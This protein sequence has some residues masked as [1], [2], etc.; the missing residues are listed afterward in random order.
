[1]TCVETATLEDAFTYFE[2]VSLDSVRPDRV[3]TRGGAEV[4]L[5]GAGLIDGSR[6]R[7]GGAEAIEVTP[8]E[9]SGD[10]IVIVPPGPPGPADVEVTNFNGRDRLPGGIFYY[11]DLDVQQINPPVGP[12]GGGNQVELLGNGLLAARG[13]H[14]VTMRQRCLGQMMNARS[15]RS[16]HHVVPPQGQR[17]SSSKTTTVSVNSTT[18]TSILMILPTTFRLPASRHRVD[19]WRVVARFGSREMALALRRLSVLRAGLSNVNSST[20]TDCVVP[21]PQGKSRRAG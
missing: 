14:L 16:M 19:P 17:I 4:R 11:E 8:D 10:L 5:S 12:L 3:P 7:I 6:V 1:M 2:E 20:Q 9:A 13:S 18:P 21:L 15:L